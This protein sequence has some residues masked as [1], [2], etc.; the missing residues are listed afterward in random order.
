[1]TQPGFT[2]VDLV[3]HSGTSADGEFLQ[4]LHLTDIYT[5]WVESRAVMGKSQTVVSAALEQLRTVLPFA[6]RGLNSDNGGEC[7]NTH[8]CR[9]CAGREIQFTRGRPYRKTTMRILIAFRAR[10]IAVPPQR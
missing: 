8:L 1:M 10:V 4:S 9:Y 5:G 2:E 3:S 7:I 6:L